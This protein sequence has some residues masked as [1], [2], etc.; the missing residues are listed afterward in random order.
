MEYKTF[1]YYP[2]DSFMIPVVSEIES[3]C[4]AFHFHHKILQE[5]GVRTSIPIKQHIERQA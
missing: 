2:T 3:L 5:A 1:E 4:E